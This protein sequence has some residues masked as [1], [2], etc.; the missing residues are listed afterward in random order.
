MPV[1][2]DEGTWNPIAR[3]VFSQEGLQQLPLKKVRAVTVVGY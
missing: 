1:P 3:K 2:S